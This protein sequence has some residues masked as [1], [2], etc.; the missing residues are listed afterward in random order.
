MEAAESKR[1]FIIS[2]RLECGIIHINGHNLC[3]STVLLRRLVKYIC[4]GVQKYNREWTME[5]IDSIHGI[6]DFRPTK[7]VMMRDSQ[8]SRRWKDS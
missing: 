4:A 7:A 3:S 5:R 2:D 1:P 6:E 8:F